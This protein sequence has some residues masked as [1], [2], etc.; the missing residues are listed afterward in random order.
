MMVIDQLGREHARMV[1][2]DDKYKQATRVIPNALH[3]LVRILVGLG[4]WL[5]RNLLDYIPVAGPGIAKMTRHAADAFIDSW[6]DS[7]RRKPFYVAAGPTSWKLLP[8][9]TKEYRQSLQVWREKM[10]NTIAIGIAALIVS[11]LGTL[12]MIIFFFVDD[13]IFDGDLSFMI[14]P[15]FF[16]SFVISA[17]GF[18]VGNFFL[19]SRMAA[20]AKERPLLERTAVVPSAAA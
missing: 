6:R 2:P 7:F 20:V 13:K 16:W 15:R 8:G 14:S 17:V 18:W 4:F 1:L 9:A 12:G 5:D 19:Q 3:A 10:F 11:G